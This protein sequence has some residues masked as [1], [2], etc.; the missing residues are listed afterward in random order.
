MKGIIAAAVAF[1]AYQG[2]SVALCTT[3]TCGA[4]APGTSLA[5][6]AVVA[7]VAA[8]MIRTR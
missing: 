1:A 2:L 3:G 7:I 4:S 6:G 5:F 8:L